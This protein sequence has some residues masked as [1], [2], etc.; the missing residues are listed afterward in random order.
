MMP[1]AY[2]RQGPKNWQV[3]QQLDGGGADIALE[4]IKVDNPD[5]GGGSVFARA[6]YEETGIPATG[7]Q[8][9]DDGPAIPA[10][11]L[12]L[13]GDGACAAW[14]VTL[15]DVPAGGLYRIET[16][17]KPHSNP[18]IEWAAHG[19]MIH[20]VG[21]G[22]VYVIAGQSNAAGYG[23]D[24]IFDPPEPGVH[25]LRNSGAWDMASHPLNDPT[26][27]AHEANSEGANPG[28]SPYLAFARRIKKSLGYPIG[29]IQ[30]ALGGSPLS[31]WSPDESGELYRNMM[32]I[33]AG[34]R[35]AIKGIL[36][37]QGCSDADPER[38][39]TYLGRFAAMAAHMRRDLKDPRLPILTFQLNRYTYTS[40]E[41]TSDDGWSAVREAQRMAARQIDNVFVVPTIDAGLS[42]AI[43][44]S[45]A[46]NMALGER[47]AACALKRIYGKPYGFEAPD[48]ASATRTPDGGAA[49]EF[50]PV[51]DRIY[52]FDACAAALPFEASD[53]NGRLSLTGYEVDGARVT[54]RFDRALGDGAHISYAAGAN[55]QGVP[56]IDMATHAPI[57]AFHRVP[58]A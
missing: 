17:L 13:A 8:R 43:H 52:A 19:D 49:L 46:G 36:W 7:W 30:A 4:G 53:S 48:I 33:V 50:A 39:P 1:G 34:T 29:L 5:D 41:A 28:H 11:D 25:L 31:A 38:A 56:A 15:R 27:T 16:C 18:N 51:L 55:P 42:D 24:F 37:Y 26:R 6:V 22:D 21:V 47:L 45:A 20:H 40:A 57:L 44:I 23:K 32:E 14:N 10:A 35:G 2:L 9:A 58:I 3:V 12:R 54:L